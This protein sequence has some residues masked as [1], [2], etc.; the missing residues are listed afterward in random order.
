[1]T[2]AGAQSL[3]GRG[4]NTGHLSTTTTDSGTATAAIEGSNLGTADSE[5]LTSPC[6]MIV[7]NE[8]CRLSLL[9]SVDTPLPTND[10]IVLFVTDR[11]SHVWVRFRLLGLSEC[12]WAGLSLR[13]FAS[14]TREEMGRRPLPDV[15]QKKVIA[16]IS[17]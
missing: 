16:L 3:E 10:E 12:E 5:S 2:D 13:A 4:V 15:S 9:N 17:T 7:G 1:M 8:D 14:S 6:V 11:R